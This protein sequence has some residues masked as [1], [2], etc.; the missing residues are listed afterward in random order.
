MKIMRNR[1]TVK[2]AIEKAEQDMQKKSD[3]NRV[4]KD[5]GVIDHKPL[6]IS[7]FIQ[8]SRIRVS[9]FLI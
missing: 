7:I 3:R 5:S 4:D 1:K 2:K 9:L 6:S 8:K